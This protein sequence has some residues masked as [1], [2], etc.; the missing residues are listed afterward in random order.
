MGAYKIE[1]LAVG[2][3]GCE[4]KAKQGDKLH[5]RCR[6]MDCPDC[7]AYE[8]IQTLRAKGMLSDGQAQG[9]ELK[10]GEEAP[11][12]SEIYYVDAK[13]QIVPSPVEGGKTL[14]KRM[15]RA[16]FTHWP[17]EPNQVVDDMIKNERKEG[18]F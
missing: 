2:G 3:H 9:N 11:P 14:W 10:P 8:F 6:R 15:Q 5:A 13:W 17:G 1:I 4:R 16:T 18:H 12:D 7:V